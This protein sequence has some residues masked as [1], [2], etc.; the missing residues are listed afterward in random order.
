MAGNRQT[1]C[2]RPPAKAS[3]TRSTPPEAIGLTMKKPQKRSGC[4]RTA[5]DTESSSPGTLAMSAAFAT[6][7][8]SRFR[9]QAAARSS[10]LAGMRHSN[11][12]P[13]SSTS[14]GPTAPWLLSPASRAKKA[15]EKKCTCASQTRKSPHGVCIGIVPVH[16]TGRQSNLVYAGHIVAAQLLHKHLPV[17]AHRLQTQVE[18]H[19]DILAG[20]AFGHQPQ[21]LQFAR[22]EGVQ[23]RLTAGGPQ[24]AGLD[25]GQQAVG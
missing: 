23:R 1:P 9:F 7:Y 19:R 6:L 13:S 5:A 10:Q 12:R 22:R 25:A 2:S 18:Q 15:G 21:H 11:L 20:L 14:I 16:Q 17:T 4:R 8:S 3:C 24:I